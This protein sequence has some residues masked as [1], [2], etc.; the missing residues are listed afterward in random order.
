[1]ILLGFIFFFL[2]YCHVL[3]I[4][5]LFLIPSFFFPQFG[6]PCVSL[7][8][9][10]FHKYQEEKK[11]MILRGVLPF[12]FIVIRW[13]FFFLFLAFFSRFWFP[14]VFLFC[15][16]VTLSFTNLKG[17]NKKIMILFGFLLSFLLTVM[18]WSIVSFLFCFFK[19]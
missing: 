15:F 16:F 2:F 4:R 19:S 14:Y 11:T 1:M 13:S 5:N 10:K 17:K 18:F 6:F 12:P 9:K 7:S 8:V 3:V